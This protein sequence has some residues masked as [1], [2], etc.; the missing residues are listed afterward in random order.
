MN[1]LKDLALIN[2][3]AIKSPEILSHIETSFV[4]HKSLE[5]FD[6]KDNQIPHFKNISTLLKTNKKIRILN[7]RGSQ[8]TTDQLEMICFGLRDNISLIEIHHQTELL[9]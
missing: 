6:L 7:I 8:M 2:L 5:V 9:A 1:K 4:K 3:E